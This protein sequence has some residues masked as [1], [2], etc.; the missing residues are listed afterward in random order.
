MGLSGNLLTIK[1]NL[2]AN[3]QITPWYWFMIM[4]VVAIAGF[5]LL[6]NQNS[7]HADRTKTNS[8][9]LWGG[10]ALVIVALLILKFKI[11]NKTGGSG[12]PE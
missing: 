5:I 11:I 4:A 1:N 6:I 9:Y 10:I 7:Y 8:L 2:M 12:N 3:K